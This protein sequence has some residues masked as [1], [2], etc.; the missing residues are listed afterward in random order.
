MLSPSSTAQPHGNHI[1]PFPLSF[2]EGS[3]APREIN[4]DDSMDEKGTMSM[5]C[6]K[7]HI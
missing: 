2:F 7:S 6:S 5:D 3:N 4:R 1:D